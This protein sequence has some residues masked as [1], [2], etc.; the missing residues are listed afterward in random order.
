M[1]MATTS[2]VAPLAESTGFSVLPEATHSSG[3]LSG[4]MPRSLTSHA[5]A[6]LMF[7]SVGTGGVSRLGADAAHRATSPRSADVRSHAN[8][9]VGAGSLRGI[10]TPEGLG[11]IRAVLSLNV[12]QLAATLSVEHA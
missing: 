12:K 3:S 7:F 10:A 1:S 5:V 11:E 4:F 6:F 9:V 2:L 8:L